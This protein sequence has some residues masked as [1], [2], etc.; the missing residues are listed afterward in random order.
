MCPNGLVYNLEVEEHHNYF[1]NGVLVHNCHHSTAPSYQNVFERFGSYRGECFTL[2]VTA[3]DHRMDNKPLHGRDGAI[4]EEVVFRYTLREAIGDGWLC[5]LRGYRV[6]TDVD[7]SGV[8]T[9]AGDYNQGQL[10]DAVNIDARNEAAFKHWYETAGERRTIVFCVD[11]QHARDVAQL[12]REKGVAA[13]H[14]DGSMRPEDRQRI[15]GAFRTGQTQVLTNCEL[16]TEGVDVPEIG[17]VLMLRPTKSWALFTQMVGRGLRI[18]EGKVDC[19]VIDVVDNT[20]SHRLGDRPAVAGLVG[21][22][23]QLDLEGQT[24][25]DALSLFEELG[26][27]AQARL[28]Q[29]DAASFNDLRTGIKEVDLLAELSVPE[30]ISGATRHAW[31]KIGEG[32]YVLNCGSSREEGGPKNR[33]ASIEVDELGSARIRLRSDRG[34]EPLVHEHDLRRAFSTADSAVRLLWPDCAGIVARKAQW[35]ERPPSEGQMR[36]LRRLRVPSATLE[37]VRT[38]GEASALIEKCKAGGRV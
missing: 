27:M 33:E 19:V 11:V 34:T 23:A 29:R 5:D 26:G 38:M 3:T 1:A 8:R 17:C 13:A 30:E 6:R 31:L 14:V 24:L 7:L 9:T 37:A 25:Q 20:A 28:F 4:F 22:P 21:L 12:F 35:R 36:F 32:R 16:V 15:M 2:G 10:A 18:S